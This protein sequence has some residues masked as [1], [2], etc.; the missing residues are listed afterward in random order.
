MMMCSAGDELIPAVSPR[1]RP[2]QLRNKYLPEPG[3]TDDPD[4]VS[5][6][7][8]DMRLDRGGPSLAKCAE[9]AARL[10]NPFLCA[11]GSDV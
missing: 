2:A 10:K 9:A 3:R 6:D 1:Q 7:C 8:L 4:K 11:A 5:R